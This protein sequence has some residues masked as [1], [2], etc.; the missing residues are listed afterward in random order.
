MKNKESNAVIWNSMLGGVSVVIA[1]TASGG[2]LQRDVVMWRADCG[3]SDAM[4]ALRYANS[5][6]YEEIK[7]M[8]CE[9]HVRGCQVSAVTA[10]FRAAAPVVTDLNIRAVRPRVFRKGE[11]SGDRSKNELSRMRH[12]D[13]NKDVNSVGGG[14]EGSLDQQKRRT[15]Q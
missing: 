8:K 11:H 14:V 6:Q 5:C 12:V 10:G 13:L 15:Q 2:G 9:S 3:P 4:N 1:R 7:E